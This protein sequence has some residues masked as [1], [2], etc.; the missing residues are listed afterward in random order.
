MIFMFVYVLL[1]AFVPTLN[2]KFLPILQLETMTMKY[3]GLGLLAIALNWTIIA[4]VHL[5]NT[6]RIGI[7]TE[8]KKNRF[9]KHIHKR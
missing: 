9:I 2:D 5:K 4:Q 3:V 8:K 7:D 6:W 1:F